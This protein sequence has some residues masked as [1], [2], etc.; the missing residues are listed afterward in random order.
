MSKA[1]GVLLLF[2]ILALTLFAGCGGSAAPDPP[3]GSRSAE[4]RQH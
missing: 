1:T 4:R 2:V 3:A